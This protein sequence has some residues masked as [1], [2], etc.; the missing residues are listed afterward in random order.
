MVTMEQQP[1]RP[2][3]AHSSLP[4]DQPPG[5]L[6]EIAMIPNLIQKVNVAKSG[7][8]ERSGDR[9]GRAYGYVGSLHSEEGERTGRIE[10]SGLAIS[11]QKDATE[12]G[13]GLLVTKHDQGASPMPEDRQDAN[14]QI[15]KDSKDD[16]LLSGVNEDSR[17]LFIHRLSGPENTKYSKPGAQTSG[18]N[19]NQT[20][21]V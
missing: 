18:I 3:S 9:S 21:S 17:D 13:D 7:T 15:S 6:E 12:D 16:S 14:H 2:D 11:R 10:S 19:S 1:A 4:L 5:P 8:G 20:T